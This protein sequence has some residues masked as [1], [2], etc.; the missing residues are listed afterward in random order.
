MINKNIL[1]TTKGEFDMSKLGAALSGITGIKLPEII[2]WGRNHPLIAYIASSDLHKPF[3]D[4]TLRFNLNID[5]YG[6]K[7]LNLYYYS[8]SVMIRKL[9]KNSM[10]TLQ[11]LDIIVKI[12]K[13]C[14][15][16]IC[17]NDESIRKHVLGTLKSMQDITL[18]T[19]E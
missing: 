8:T 19:N 14:P 15:S 13:E 2:Q 12:R 6:V 9:S 1:I 18:N 11:D 4:C 10:I 3:V 5:K 16:N 7:S 17:H